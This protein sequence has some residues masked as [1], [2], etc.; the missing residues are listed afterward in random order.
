MRVLRSAVEKV[1]DWYPYLFLDSHVAACVA[2]L[3][4]Y[5]KSPGVFQVDCAG[6]SSDWLGGSNRLR[7]EL[8]WKA[9]TAA[10]AARLRDTIQSR[11][12]VEMAATSVAFVIAHRVLG[13][14]RL[15]VTAYGDRVDYR[16]SLRRKVLEISGT[17]RA[18]M[19]DR[20]H[21]EKVAQARKNPLHWDAYV[22]VCAFAAPMHRIRM[23]HHRVGVIQP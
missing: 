4:K 8:T 13:L 7:L 19:L 6:I 17:E 22:I 15:F 18:D 12:L 14:R 21:R 20:R 11:P 23:S 16:S 10:K 2:V 3:E 5:S 9:F 1:I